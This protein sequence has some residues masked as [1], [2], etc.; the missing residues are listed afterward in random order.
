MLQTKSTNSQAKC[1]GVH[2]ILFSQLRNTRE[3]YTNI[4]ITITPDYYYYYN[5][6]C[7]YY[8]NYYHYHDL[9]FYYY[10]YNYNYLLKTNATDYSY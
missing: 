9:N 10:Y 1:T 7:Y 2:E 4:T 6:C 8:Y 5:H 3:K